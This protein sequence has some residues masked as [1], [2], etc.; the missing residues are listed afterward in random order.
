MIP[1]SF[2]PELLKK[3]D[4]FIRDHES[5][6]V[7]HRVKNRVLY[8]DTDR[9]GVVYHSNYLRYFELGRVTLMRQIG[10]PYAEVE[11]NGFVYPVVNMGLDFHRSLQYD[12][13]MWIYTRPDRLEKVKVSFSYL[14]TNLD[15]E[16]IVCTGH[17]VH[18]ALNENRRPCA[19]DPQT[20][21]IW[22]KFPK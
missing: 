9:S 8:I 2:K 14:I 5:G 1:R 19:V 10:Y 22:Q 15:N 7:W 17:T 6:L 3:D 11:A 13:P 4:N 18:C 12:D 16:Q 20:V 21:S